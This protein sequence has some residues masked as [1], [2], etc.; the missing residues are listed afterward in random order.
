MENARDRRS[1]PRN[2]EHEGCRYLSLAKLLELK[3]AC[4][5]S[6]PDR[7]QDFADVIALVRENRLGPH[8]GE[9]LHPYVQAKYAE[10]WGL[11]QRPTL[12]P[13]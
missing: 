3:I 1:F 13:E 4:A 8:F 9:A 10:L 12:L 6:A 2:G 7:L 5:L 11:A